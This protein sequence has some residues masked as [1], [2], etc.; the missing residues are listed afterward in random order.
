MWW[1]WELYSNSKPEI[2]RISYDAGELRLP[3]VAGGALLSYSVSANIH[4]LARIELG[5]D[6]S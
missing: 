3:G 1:L 6:N 2:H 5:I 4:Q